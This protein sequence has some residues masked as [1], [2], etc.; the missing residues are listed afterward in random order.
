MNDKV[1][2]A[3]TYSYT[4]PRDLIQMYLEG[5]KSSKV[6]NVIILWLATTNEVCKELSNLMEALCLIRLGIGI[7]MVP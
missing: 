6:R 2:D 3:N 1:Y 5:F 7:I 4:I